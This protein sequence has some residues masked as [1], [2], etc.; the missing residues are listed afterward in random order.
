MYVLYIFGNFMHVSLQ[1]SDFDEARSIIAVRQ[2][3]DSITLITGLPIYVNSILIPTYVSQP[4]MMMSDAPD[5]GPPPDGR[6]SILSP[7]APT[8]FTQGVFDKDDH[9]KTMYDTLVRIDIHRSP[10]A[11]TDYPIK[12]FLRDFL[13]ALKKVNEQNS[14]L[15]IEPASNLGYITNDNDIPSGEKLSKYVDG[16]SV[17]TNKRPNNNNSNVI[18]FHL[19]ISTTLPLWQLKRNTMFYAWLTKG[20]IF[21][22]THGFT[23]TY[24][25]LSAGFLGNMSPTMHRHDTMM[26]IIHA[27]A[28]KKNLNIEIRLVPRNIPYGQSEEKNTTNA[29][30]VLADRASVHNVREMMIEIF[31]QKPNEIPTDIYFIPSPTHGA[32]THELYYKHLCLHHQYTANLRSFGITNVNDIHAMLML[33]Q[34]DGTVK[35]TTFKKA[36]LDSVKPNTQTRLFKLIEPMKDTEK[37]GKY[38]LIRLSIY[39]KMRKHAWTKPSNICW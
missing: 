26:D 3:G 31:Q 33:P 23:T 8:V 27:T 13:Q 35:S 1:K 4:T 16:I 19:R 17:P 39:W 32:M 30:E 36:L 20:R 2:F 22:C 29:V 9:A 24:D 21:L 12:P 38:L 7:N 25:V 10:N 18:G 6:P 14:I 15:P 37:Y 5:T 34:P 11:V 28:Q